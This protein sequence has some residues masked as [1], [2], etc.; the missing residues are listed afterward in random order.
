MSPNTSTPP[1]PKR[2][3]DSRSHFAI[4]LTV[5]FLGVSWS[6]WLAFVAEE[7]FDS[8]P[9]YLV[10]LVFVA[11]FLLTILCFLA[12]HRRVPSGE[13]EYDAACWLL[14]RARRKSWP[15]RA[16]VSR[17]AARILLWIPS[18]IALVTIFFFPAATH[19]T[20]LGQQR[21]GPYG[22]DIPWTIAMISF[23]EVPANTAIAAYAL[24][25]K[26]GHPGLRP[27]WIGEMF[28]SEMVFGNIE[29]ADATGDFRDR[30]RTWELEGVREL[31][32]RD[33]RSGALT[34]TCWQFLPK[35]SR[36]GSDLWQVRC[37]TRVGVKGNHFYASF[38]GQ[39]ADLPV[40][41]RIV[42]RVR[43]LP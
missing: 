3:P 43:A 36:R 24:A 40:F 14:V 37:E 32:Q 2:P 5:L 18:L 13:T 8:G 31:T 22:I 15:R 21:V 9:A 23:P 27:F 7:T 1:P 6:M 41:Y 33:M 34:V 20:R 16:H 4:E 11:G 12:I 29:H 26:A 42:E 17:M 10:G 39:D 25:G 35:P 30:L 19:L 38:R 28:S